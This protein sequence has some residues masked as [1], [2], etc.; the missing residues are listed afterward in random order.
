MIYPLPPE[1][2]VQA[3]ID[4]FCALWFIFIIYQVVRL[5]AAICE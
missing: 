4:V 5:V 3:R 2:A 1:S